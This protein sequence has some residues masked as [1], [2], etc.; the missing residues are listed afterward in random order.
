MIAN[1]VQQIINFNL[2]QFI[3]IVFFIIIMIINDAE[4]FL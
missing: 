3:A 2:Y 1:D 4:N